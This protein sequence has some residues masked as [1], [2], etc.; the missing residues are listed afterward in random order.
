MEIRTLAGATWAGLMAVAEAL[1][2][3]WAFCTD[4]RLGVLVLV[5]LLAFNVHMKEHG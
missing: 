3:I 5:F 2:L 1:A 4:W